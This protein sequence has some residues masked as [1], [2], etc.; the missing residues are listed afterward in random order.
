MAR[1]Q[2]GSGFVQIL[3]SREH[4]LGKKHPRVARKSDQIESVAGIKFVERVVDERLRFFD[5]KAHHRTRCIEHEHEFFGRDIRFRDARRW[6]QDQGKVSAWSKI[7]LCRSC[8]REN[9]VANLISGN[10]VFQDEI[11]I[12]NLGKILELDRRRAVAHPVHHNF[13]R[14]GAQFL[15]R[16]TRIDRKVDRNVMSSTHS[17]RRDLRRDF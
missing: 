17:R 14:T 16:H 9:R 2:N 7:A 10:A 15:N 13:M 6:L 5:G 8:L 11:L 1:V 4:G 12:R 3:R